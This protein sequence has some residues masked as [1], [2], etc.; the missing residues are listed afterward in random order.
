MLDFC[1]FTQNLG[2]KGLCIQELIFSPVN[3]IFMKIRQFPLRLRFTSIRELIELSG[4]T[5]GKNV[6]RKVQ[7]DNMKQMKQTKKN[8]SETGY[9]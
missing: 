1:L 6:F 2:I 8:Y 7:A 4:V 5:K 9:T 3:D